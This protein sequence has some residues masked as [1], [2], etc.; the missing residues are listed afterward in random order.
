MTGEV[1]PRGLQLFFCG[2][3]LWL[4]LWVATLIRRGQ[5][6]L[7][8]SFFWLL[9][10]LLALY[11]GAFPDALVRSAHLLGVV[12]PANALFAFTLLYL[13]VNQLATT[14]AVSRVTVN[15]RRL[16]QEAALLRGE[17]DL[18]RGGGPGLP[19]RRSSRA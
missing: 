13:V 12:V 5:L 10:S 11:L 14:I 19:R 7:R 6:S 8:D 3:L 18:M 15:V 2:V 17:L 4:I 16:A 1:V 9:S